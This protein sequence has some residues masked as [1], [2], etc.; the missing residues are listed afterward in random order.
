MREDVHIALLL[1]IKKVQMMNKHA[2]CLCAT[3]IAQPGW[4]TQEYFQKCQSS[5]LYKY[6]FY[7][8]HMP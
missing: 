3:F 1:D 5:P 8:K 7:S 6:D 2:V 4:S